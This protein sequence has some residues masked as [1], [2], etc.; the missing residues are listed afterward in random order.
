MQKSIYTPLS[1]ALAQERVLELIANNLANVNTNGYKEDRVTFSLL[2]PE[3]EKHYKEPLPPANYKIDLDK[4]LP[5]VGNEIA[6]VGI[7]DVTRTDNQGPSIETKNPLNLLIEGEGFFS[8]MTEDGQRLTRDGALQLNANGVLVTA[9]GH[10]VLGEKGDVLVRGGELTVNAIGEIWQD[11]QLVDRLLIQKV[12]DQKTLE[13]TGGNYYFYGGSPEGIKSLDTPTVRQGWIE[14]SNVNPIKN[15]T[16]MIIAHRSYEAYQ[17][18][19]KNYDSIME[20][21]SNTL[22][23]V[24]G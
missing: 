8:V 3:P 23:E 21:S 1:G 20:H 15:L 13:R 19:I 2:K 10:P 24:R 14:G 22:G 7:A 17:K 12:D 4:L 16:N 11:G 6:Y 18:A 9:S 5:F